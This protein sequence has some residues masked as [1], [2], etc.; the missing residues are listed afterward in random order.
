MNFSDPRLEK[1]NFENIDNTEYDSQRDFDSNTLKYSNISQ[2]NKLSTV[3]DV[4]NLD[5]G[6]RYQS[7]EK[8]NYVLK[9]DEDFENLQFESE[10]Y[11]VYVNNDDYSHDFNLN[12]DYDNNTFSNKKE[13]ILEKKNEKLQNISEEGFYFFFFFRF[14]LIFYFL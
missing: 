5:S 11:K 4:N 12:Q 1:K 6:D 3:F 9:N 10:N 14:F 13:K 8:L 2:E 7:N